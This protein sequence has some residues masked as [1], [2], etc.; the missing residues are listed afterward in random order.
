[1]A[2]KRYSANVGKATI[3]ALRDMGGSGSRKDIRRTIADNGYE[4][5]T[6]EDVFGTITSKKT[7]NEYCPFLLE[8]NFGLKN[9][10]AT[11]LVEPL[12]RGHDVELTEEGFK[13][14]IDQYPTKQQGKIIEKYW[15]DHSGI[16][17]KN[18]QPAEVDDEEPVDELSD[19]DNADEKWKA[20]LLN[21]IKKFS[22]AKF[23]RFSRLLVTKMGVKM[24]KTIGVPLS[25]D[26][27][28]DGFGYFQSDDFR[29]SRVAIQCKRYDTNYVG[30][31]QI[32]DFIGAMNI[33]KAEYG[34][35][36]TTSY[37]TQ[38]AKAIA[39]KG[40]HPV[41]LIDGRALT[42]LIEKYQLKIHPV[43]TYELDDYYYEED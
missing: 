1:M 2:Y 25:G 37:F 23:E 16:H 13:T 14:D 30:E 6:Q 18:Q 36:I 11:G 24:D 33:Q 3:L 20:D 29:T 12:V 38:Q 9:L 42:D 28:L 22:S 17:K 19:Q 26:H 35:F 39:V 10:S 34:I 4:G 31:S 5:L 41:T 27:G 7:G 43:T 40:D 8:F 21:A 15:D 32:R